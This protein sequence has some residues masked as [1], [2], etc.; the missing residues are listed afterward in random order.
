ML[1]KHDD[2]TG[3][4]GF[5]FSGRTTYSSA[6]VDLLSIKLDAKLSFESHISQICKKASGQLNTLKCLQGSV[7]S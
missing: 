3:G 2:Q 1:T 4:S 5:N 6:E 7:I